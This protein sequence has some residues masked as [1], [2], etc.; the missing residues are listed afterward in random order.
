MILSPSLSGSLYLRLCISIC[1]S[2]CVCL[3]VSSSSLDFPFRFHFPRHSLNPQTPLLTDL[4]YYRRSLHTSLQGPS[5]TVVAIK[6]SP[7][8]T[9][10]LPPTIFPVRLVGT[11]VTPLRPVVP[12]TYEVDFVAPSRRTG[13]ETVGT[14]PLDTRL[15]SES[16]H[17]EGL[18]STGDTGFG[19]RELST[20]DV[21]CSVLGV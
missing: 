19:P 4:L 14:D 5:S 16:R 10:G 13:L 2:V 21:V 17:T 7:T 20:V 18:V 11:T 1:H 9:R 15:T 8:P 3:S 12:C 6:P